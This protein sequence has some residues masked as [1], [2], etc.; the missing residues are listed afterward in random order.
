MSV[1]EIGTALVAHP[2]VTS[3]HDLHVWEI[4]SGF[5]ALSAHVLVH[6]GDDCHAIRQELELMLEERFEIEHTTL[7]V[8]HDRGR[9]APQ[10][11]ALARG[12]MRGSL[13]YEVQGAVG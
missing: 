4:G 9:S 6:A 10:D 2:H 11:H 13:L 5:P 7:Q 8:D 12:P 1:D 3:V